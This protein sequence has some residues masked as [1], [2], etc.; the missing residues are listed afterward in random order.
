MFSWSKAKKHQVVIDS[1][2]NEIEMFIRSIKG[3]SSREK[4]ALLFAAQK[5]R[6]ELESSGC[7]QQEILNNPYSID[8][9]SINLEL[10]K[11]LTEYANN[12]MNSGDILTYN[13]LILWIFTLR[14]IAIPEI[15]LQGRELW[16]ILSKN[17]NEAISSSAKVIRK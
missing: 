4:G 12:A 17:I 3:S 1:A 10:R 16:E 6:T 11:T 2:T 5:L 7:F 9:L 14:A 15:R 8:A 13:C